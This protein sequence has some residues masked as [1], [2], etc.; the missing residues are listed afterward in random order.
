MYGHSASTFN[1]T[2]QVVLK[3]M[4]R[5]AQGSSTPKRGL[6]R[7][8]VNEATCVEGIPTHLRPSVV[9][10]RVFGGVSLN[11][12]AKEFPFS[13]IATGLGKVW[14]RVIGYST[15]TVDASRS[16]DKTLGSRNWFRSSV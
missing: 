16:P 4:L 3:T 13:P 1:Y 8:A 15:S 14:D 12:P 2:P 5:F 9:P 11:Q 7:A 6:K 10:S